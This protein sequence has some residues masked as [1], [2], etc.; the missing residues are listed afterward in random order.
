M[1]Y[2]RTPQN[3]RIRLEVIPM[4]DKFIN[5]F[6]DLFPDNSMKL[7]PETSECNEA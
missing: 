5:E 3:S 4:E 7:K 6:Q 1:S 2:I